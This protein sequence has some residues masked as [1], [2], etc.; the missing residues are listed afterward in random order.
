[1]NR[2]GTSKGSGATYS[3]LRERLREKKHCRCSL[4]TLQFG[5]WLIINFRVKGI[6]D[7]LSSP[8][9]EGLDWPLFLFRAP[10]PSNSTILPMSFLVKP[11][12][13]WFRMYSECKLCRQ[14]DCRSIFSQ[15][16]RYIVYHA[17]NTC[18]YV[19][20]HISWWYPTS[21]GAMAD[22][23][24]PMSPVTGQSPWVK[25]RGWWCCLMA[26]RWCTP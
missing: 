24:K 23:W 4:V 12:W 17:F 16:D 25:S 9:P 14:S 18:F 10:T 8:F 6:T 15:I 7:I 22:A 2:P 20:Q 3:R 13:I 26:T 21:I 5:W 11:G 19:V 1:M